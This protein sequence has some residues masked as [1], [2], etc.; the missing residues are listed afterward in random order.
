MRREFLAPIK[1]GTPIG[2]VLRDLTFTTIGEESFTDA[3]AVREVRSATSRLR[4]LLCFFALGGCCLVT[5][6]SVM[7]L[8]VREAYRSDHALMLI[9]LG[10]FGA[11]AVLAGL[12]AALSRFTRLRFMG[13]GLAVLPFFVF[14]R[15]FFAVEPIFNELIL[16]DAAGNLTFIALCAQGYILLRTE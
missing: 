7:E 8:T 2:G 4:R 6:A 9:S 13:F 12:F 1:I 14:D 3:H 10:A 15:W 16:L 5:P 11:Q